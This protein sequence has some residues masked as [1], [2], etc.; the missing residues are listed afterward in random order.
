MEM[1]E[2][3]NSTGLWQIEPAL[4]GAYY[5]CTGETRHDP[6]LSHVCRDDPAADHGLH[7]GQQSSNRTQPCNLR[8]RWSVESQRACFFVSNMDARSTIDPH[9]INYSY[10]YCWYWTAAFYHCNM[11]GYVQMGRTC[12]L[13]CSSKAI[14]ARPLSHLGILR[15]VVL[16]RF[17]C[18][19]HRSGAVLAFGAEVWRGLLVLRGTSGNRGTR[20]RGSALVSKL[21]AIPQRDRNAKS[22]PKTLAN[23]VPSFWALLSSFVIVPCFGGPPCRETPTHTHTHTHCSASLSLGRSPRVPEFAMTSGV[24]GPVALCGCREA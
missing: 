10:N 12:W 2:T 23:T 5:S 13:Q 22:I 8:G 19:S 9:I 11:N 4:F 24:S 7:P 20:H 16:I 21:T 15:A 1:I 14:V 6:V 3:W 17:P 18:R